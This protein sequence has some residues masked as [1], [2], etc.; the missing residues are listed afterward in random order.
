MY[1]CV[2]CTK[3][4]GGVFISIYACLLRSNYN[5][6]NRT[7][8]GPLKFGP[9]FQQLFCSYFLFKWHWTYMYSNA[10]TGYYT[11]R[12]CLALFPF[13]LCAFSRYF[14]Q[15]KHMYVINVIVKTKIV[16]CTHNIMVFTIMCISILTHTSNA[17]CFRNVTLINIWGLVV[18]IVPFRGYGRLS[19]PLGSWVSL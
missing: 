11:L 12:E 1:P 3:F 17:K 14:R 8:R 9:I 19:F 7:K 6:Y 15:N 13:L 16:K 4:S 18:I 2:V 10:E 5:C